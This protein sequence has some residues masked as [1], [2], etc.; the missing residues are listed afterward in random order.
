MGCSGSSSESQNRNR[1]KKSADKN[2]H[3]SYSGG[4]NKFGTAALQNNTT[5]NRK[6]RVGDEHTSKKEPASFRASPVIA[7]NQTKVEK[8]HLDKTNMTATKPKG[9]KES[10]SSTSNQVSESSLE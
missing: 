6:L 8:Y 5:S 3:K 9:T 1:S 4:G 7:T 10:K 2:M